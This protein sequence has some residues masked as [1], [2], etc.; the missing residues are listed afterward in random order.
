MAAANFFELEKFSINSVLLML[1]VVALFLF[2][3][4]EFDH[5][6]DV[7]WLVSILP[8]CAKQFTIKQKEP[9]AG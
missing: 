6:N 5:A 4:S 1:Q 7:S 2:Y 8:W 9:S 3:I